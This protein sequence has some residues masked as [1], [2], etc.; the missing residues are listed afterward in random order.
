MKIAFVYDRLNKIGGAERIL[1]TIHQIWPDAPFYTA[2]H[3]L[4]GAPLSKR[5][6]VRTS[7]MQ[8]IP[9]AKT[10][11]ELYP[12]L[13]PFAFESFSLDFDIVISI[14]SAEAKGVITKPS[15]LHICYCLTP[16]RYL[17]SH[18]S[19]YQKQGLAWLKPLQYFLLTK[20]RAWDQIAVQRPDHYLTISQTVRHRITKYYRRDAAVIYPPVNTDFFQPA[21]SS[22][23]VDKLA[24]L[25]GFFLV[26]SRLVAYKRIDIAIKACNQLNLP[27]VIVGTGRMLSKLKRLAGASVKFVGKLTD[28]ELL[29]YYQNC[30][31]LIF[32]GEEDF[33]LTM[34]EAQSVG[35]PVIAL[36]QGGATEIIKAGKTGLFFDKP[37]AAS[38]KPVLRRFKAQTFN[39]RQIRDNVLKFDQKKFKK[40]FQATIESLWQK[41]QK[42]YR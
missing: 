40:R 20:L 27:L 15:T 16:T 37:T 13:T 42:S 17:W 28:Q 22:P 21:A 7:F 18:S 23:S 35:K 41:H 19:D 24:H 10:S 31:A 30:A 11:H 5:W 3:D 14:T 6:Q 36:R 33:G 29:R 39:N 8:H 38:L 26:V 4:N 2:V 25:P 32:P 34:L 1:E 12:W 9:F